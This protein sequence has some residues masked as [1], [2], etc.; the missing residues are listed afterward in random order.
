MTVE[1]F[2]VIIKITMVL[3]GLVV[4]LSFLY[5]RRRSLQI[6]ILGTHFLC[7]FLV[8]HSLGIFNLRGMDVNFPI[9]AQLLFSFLAISALYYIQFG[10]QYG[11][12]F[13]TIAG[14]FTIFWV[15]NLFLIQKEHFHSYSASIAS[16]LVMA[17][18]VIYFYRLLHDL[19]TRPLKHIPL[20]WIN[21]GFL[22]Q[23][24]QTFFLYLFT[25]YLTKFFFNDVLIYWTVSS[26]LGILHIVL[27]ITGL[28]I[29]VKNTVD[30]R[31][32]PTNALGKES[33][34]R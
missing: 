20:F 24:A 1:K 9:N 33:L 4:V 26:L 29:D 21:T 8:Y 10:R 13:A 31:Q 22:V 25:D 32:V 5:F 16:F 12:I 15:T 18:C 17:Y 14:L 30:I 7:L 3:N 19:P 2:M 28:L 23:S 11:L 27:I 6:K 34:R